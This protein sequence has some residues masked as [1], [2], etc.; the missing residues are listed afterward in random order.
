MAGYT[1]RFALP[2]PHGIDRVAAHID[3]QQLAEK[4]DLEL[5]ATDPAPLVAAAE[6]RINAGV[7]DR[8]L[9][10]QS[11][12][13]ALRGDVDVLGD[14]VGAVETLGG[15][16]PGDVSDATV[17]SLVA[18]GGTSTRVALDDLYSGAGYTVDA[19]TY[20]V[21]ADGI[22]DDSAA[23]QA[24]VAAMPEGS[25]LEF[26]P[27]RAVRLGSPFTVDRP[28]RIK[29]GKFLTDS[30]QAIVVTSTDVHIDGAEIIG[31]GTD[32]PYQIQNH[33]IDAKGTL[34]NPLKVKITNCTIR[35][36]RDSAIWLEHVRDFIIDG[37]HIQDFRYAG[38]WVASGKNGRITG[39]T[40]RDAVWNQTTECYGMAMT[41]TDG[42]IENRTDG[43]II[44]HNHV[45]NVPDRTGLDTH[46]G[47]NV[48]FAFN[49]VRN[50][51]TGITGTVGNIDRDTAPQRMVIVGNTIIGDPNYTAGTTVGIALGGSPD[52]HPLDPL[53]ADMM[54]M[55]NVIRDVV[56][57]INLPGSR[58]EK[59]D[60][61]LS[62]I[63]HNTS[64]VFPITEIPI[65]SGGTEV[66]V[67]HLGDG[68]YRIGE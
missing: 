52:G 19:A 56:I 50:C 53:W 66:V 29:G 68:V 30:G 15:L 4:V 2:Y 26:P 54:V 31:P 27:D 63:K 28:A 64:D 36:M 5:A 34:A 9:P 38:I 43:V 37:N 14:R 20:G 55:S 6:Q 17:A 49:Q 44:A 24:A 62:Q 58:G 47:I 35:G 22:T 45:I 41:G 40:V 57:P 10:V 18:Q 32:V 65:D 42:R 46:G 61:S 48:T 3:V 33:G 21:V 11:G 23:I 16:A 67:E 59:V 25:T 12:V 60:R 51:K 13:S 39:N 7:T 8:L 1:N